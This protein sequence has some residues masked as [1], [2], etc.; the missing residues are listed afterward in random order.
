MTLQLIGAGLPRTGTSSLRDALSFL[1]D[2]PVYHMS[3]ALRHP[4]HAGTW[5]AAIAGERPV[6]DEFLAGYAAGVDAPFSNCWRDLAEAYPEA[7]IVLSRR[8]DAAT[9]YRSMAATVLPR[10]REILAR[11]AADPMAP[12][13]GVIFRD[14]F[15]DMDDP[16]DVMAGYE[17]RLEQIRSEAPAD[18]LVEW[19][20]G[21]GW[22]PICDALGLAVPDRP[23]PH[24]NSTAAYVARREAR[25]QQDRRRLEPLEHT[26]R[27]Q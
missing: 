26:G 18:R 9:W 12:L 13:F 19:E 4:E 22:A 1:L 17:R 24:E 20:P 16:Q 11:G 10:T 5:V 21:D 14:V 2:A 8:V 6:W 15:D 7:P 25:A 23:F 27:D 3:E